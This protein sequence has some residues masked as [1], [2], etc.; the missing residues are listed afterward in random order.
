MYIL[1]KL[2]IESLPEW[3][4]IQ[5]FPKYEVNCREGLVRNARTLKVLNPSHDG[6]GYPFVVLCKDGKKFP[7]NVHRIVATEAF[8]YYGIPTEGLFVLHLD[9]TRTNSCIDNLALGTQRENMNFEKAKERISNAMTG[10]SL[11]EDTKMKMSESKRGKRN[12]FFAKHHSEETKKKLSVSLKGEKNPNFN[13]HLSTETRKKMSDA[14]M[15]KPVGAYKNGELV[16][17]FQSTK[18]AHRNGF[19]SSNISA[20]CLGKA[21]TYKGYKWRFLTA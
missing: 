21:K 5:G 20:C 2:Q 17:V 16:M 18:E 7:K 12:P 3:L 4:P 15:K 8:S 1:S 11:S 6:G 9:E 14:H 19:Y 10:K 13:K